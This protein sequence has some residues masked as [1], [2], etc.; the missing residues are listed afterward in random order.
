MDVHHPI[1]IEVVCTHEWDTW[2]YLLLEV[3]LHYIYIIY[4]LDIVTL[5][6]FFILNHR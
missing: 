4:T 2:G 3:L 1:L 6:A 5:Y